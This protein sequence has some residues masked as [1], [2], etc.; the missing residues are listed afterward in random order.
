MY[1]L[2][3]GLIDEGEISKNLYAVGPTDRLINIQ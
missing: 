2:L 3:Y 1:H